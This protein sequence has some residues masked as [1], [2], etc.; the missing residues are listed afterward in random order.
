MPNLSL[1]SVHLLFLKPI[2]NL[3]DSDFNFY[4]T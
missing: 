3:N 2:S 4:D 1:L